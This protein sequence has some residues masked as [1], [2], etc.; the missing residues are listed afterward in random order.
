MERSCAHE[1]LSHSLSASLSNDIQG[2]GAQGT[3][4]DP[5]RVHGLQLGNLGRELGVIRLEGHRVIPSQDFNPMGLEGRRQDIYSHA[6]G[7]RI[8]D[9]GNDR[10]FFDVVTLLEFPHDGI[11]DFVLSQSIAKGIGAIGFG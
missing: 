11:R 8:F 6:L 5:I 3:H 1:R 2:I 10:Y 7:Y 9:V 4:P